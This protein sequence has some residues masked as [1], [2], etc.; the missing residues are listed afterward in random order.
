MSLASFLRL[1]LHVFETK[2][3][4]CNVFIDKT[5]YKQKETASDWQQSD[6][7]T[8]SPL[9]TSKKSQ[10]LVRSL[11]KIYIK[12]WYILNEK[13]LTL[14]LHLWTYLTST[15]TRCK[16][17]TPIRLTVVN[18]KRAGLLGC[19]RKIFIMLCFLL[20]KDV[21]CSLACCMFAVLIIFWATNT[22][23][24]SFFFK[25]EFPVS[26]LSCWALSCL[27]NSFSSLC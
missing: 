17:S 6:A 13:H 22:S 1:Y 10:P 24:K 3:L 18:C 14:S 19:D 26:M 15:Q 12:G 25:M 8:W 20:E 4:V 7:V 27:S 16:I 9:T 23:L 21:R 2:T 11:A 5:I